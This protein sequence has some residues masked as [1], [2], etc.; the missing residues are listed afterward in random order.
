MC[1]TGCGCVQVEVSRHKFEFHKISTCHTILYA[2]FKKKYSPCKIY[3]IK[4]IQKQTIGQIWPM[5]Q[6]ADVSI[7]SWVRFV[8]YTCPICLIDS[9]SFANF[10][11]KNLG[12]N[13]MDFQQI[14]TQRPCLA[15]QQS[16]TAEW[17]WSFLWQLSELRPCYLFLPCFSHV[18]SAIHLTMTLPC[19]CLAQD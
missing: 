2:W 9:I 19:P 6:L 7:G 17:H 10:L 18:P 14:I 13:I 16:F 8:C 4:I 5:G 3:F 12:T 11:I 15:W 1:D